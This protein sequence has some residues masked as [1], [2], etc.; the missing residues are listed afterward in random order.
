M[1]T[2]IGMAKGQGLGILNEVVNSAENIQADLFSW[3]YFFLQVKAEIKFGI[4]IT[5]PYHTNFQYNEGAG[6]KTFTPA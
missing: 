6:V 5:G 4:F 2:N 1:F 3:R